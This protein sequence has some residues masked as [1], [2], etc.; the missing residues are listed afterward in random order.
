[1][2]VRQFQYGPRT[3]LALGYMLAWAAQVWNPTISK[4]AETSA[5]SYASLTITPG[6]WK[7]ISATVARIQPEL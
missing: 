3:T 2:V 5:T 6:D 4:F 7:I 1:M